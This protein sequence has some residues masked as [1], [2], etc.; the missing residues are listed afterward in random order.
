M[1]V[2]VTQ[3]CQCLCANAEKKY[4]RKMRKGGRGQQSTIYDGKRVKKYPTFLR[5]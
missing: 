4:L 5:K 2:P 3:I 1:L